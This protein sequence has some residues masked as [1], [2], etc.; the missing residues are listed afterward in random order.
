MVDFAS[1]ALAFVGASVFS[2]A[3][4]VAGHESFHAVKLGLHKR[5]LRN[6][7]VARALRRRTPPR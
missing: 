5:L 7:D 3:V 6:H 2:A 4:H 1:G